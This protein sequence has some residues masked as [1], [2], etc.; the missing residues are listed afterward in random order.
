MDE[1]RTLYVRIAMGIA[2][3]MAALY[4]F[5][6]YMT[7]PAAAADLGGN[8]CADLE[9][10]IAE[11]EAVAA[12]KGNRKVSLTVSGQ[13]NKA[14]MF[15]EDDARVIENSAAESYVAIS[16][17]ARI[18]KDWG[19]GYV[20]EIG[21]GGHDGFFTPDD[22]NEIYTRR[23]FVFVDSPIGRVSMG[24]Q[25]Q[26]TDGIAETTV[27]NTAVAGRML[28][29]RPLNGP[30]PGEVLDLWDGSRHDLVRF[31]SIEMFKGFFVS[32]S[33]SP[34]TADNTDVWDVALRYRGEGGGFRVGA[35][36]GYRRG[37][38]VPAFIAGGGDDLT[39][40]SGSA[41]AM[42]IETGLFLSGAYGSVELDGFSPS[43]KAWH[44][45]G[46]I[47]RS[48]SDLGKTTLFAE[49]AE[50]DDIDTK[51]YGLGVVQAIDAAAL[52]IYLTGRRIELLGGDEADVIMAGARVQF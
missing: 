46:G 4:L 37:V 44:V 7:P 16:G 24:R 48:W 34:N 23:S 1:K 5:M 3:A 18:N 26:A 29:L 10:R 2:A 49:A 8:C 50:A 15:I 6:S 51:L 38:V 35:G 33:W 47:E 52:D 45:Q 41:S 36:V 30:E 31:D 43:L 19:A 14:I 20:L 13:I 12:R 42:H 32:A 40:W 39:V 28:S 25:S 17:A 22:A 9:E 27:A 21:V 11:L